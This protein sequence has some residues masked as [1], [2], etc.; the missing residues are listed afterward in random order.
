MCTFSV[1]NISMFSSYSWLLQW[2]ECPDEDPIGILHFPSW[3]IAAECLGS[4]HQNSENDH[5]MFSASDW[6]S[7][8]QPTFRLQKLIVLLISQTMQNQQLA[9]VCW[10]DVK[11]AG[12]LRMGKNSWA[13]QI[14]K[15]LQ[16]GPVQIHQ[17]EIRNICIILMSTFSFI[18]FFPPPSWKGKDSNTRSFF[19]CLASFLHSWLSCCLMLAPFICTKGSCK[20]LCRSSPTKYQVWVGEAFSSSLYFGLACSQNGLQRIGCLFNNHPFNSVLHVYQSTPFFQNIQ[21][22]RIFPTPPPWG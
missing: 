20:H 7:T 2:T 5:Q 16:L 22:H 14:G 17:L 9:K 6:V 10:D 1:L 18:A 3:R 15:K 19:A 11:N 8:S 13:L 21:L 12:M 4:A